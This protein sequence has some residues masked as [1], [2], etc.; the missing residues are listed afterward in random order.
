MGYCVTLMLYIGL[1]A[2]ILFYYII[3]IN[4]LLVCLKGKQFIP[5]ELELRDVYFASRPV[6]TFRHEEAVDTNNFSKKTIIKNMSKGA[7][8]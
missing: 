3:K 7:T 1:F 4:D 6:A 2:L 5:K 8:K